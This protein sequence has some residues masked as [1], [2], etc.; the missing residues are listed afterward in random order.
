MDSPLPACNATLNGIAAVLLCWGL[1]R[2]K[3][4]DREGHRRVMLAAT[5]VSAVFLASYLWYHLGV[6]A[7]RGPTPFRR[8][9]ITKVLYLVLLISH[10]LLAIVN[11]PLIIRLL[12]LAHRG[13]FARHRRLARFVWPSWFYVSVTGVLVYLALYHWN[14]PP[15]ADVVP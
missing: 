3:H 14:L 12:L 8:E 2:I 1:W 4:G 6:Q 9:G 5:A 10:V 13:D 7:Q 15:P 11:V